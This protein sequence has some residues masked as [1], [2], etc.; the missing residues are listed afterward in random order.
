MDLDFP[1]ICDHLLLG[2][3]CTC[4]EKPEIDIT[5]KNCNCALRGCPGCLGIC[6]CGGN[7]CNSLHSDW[8]SIN[9]YLN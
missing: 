6:D 7:K 4:N 1:D 2:I 5:K 8:C 3:E 9:Q